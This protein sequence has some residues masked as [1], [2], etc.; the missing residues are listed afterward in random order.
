MHVKNVVCCMESVNFQYFLIV[1][2]MEEMCHRNFSS[3]TH[4]LNNAM[5]KDNAQNS[6]RISG[7]SFGVDKNK[8]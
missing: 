3:E 2:V 5:S 7:Y 1:C 4:C 8:V 6:Q